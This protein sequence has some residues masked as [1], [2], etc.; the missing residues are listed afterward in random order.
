M[1]GYRLTD[2]FAI[3]P[4]LI[5]QYY[6]FSNGSTKFSFSNVGARVFGQAVITDNIFIHAEH[7]VLRT[8]YVD[9]A[10]YLYPDRRTSLNSTFL[11]GGYRQHLGSRT[12]LDIM[13]LLN[14]S[15]ETNFYVY[16]QP[17]IR[18]NILFDLF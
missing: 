6:S 7:E 17:E 14:L 9:A 3:G 13:M 11:G 2:R 16:G 5:Y 1:L 18:F 8:P 12:A 4:G 15:Y 10:G